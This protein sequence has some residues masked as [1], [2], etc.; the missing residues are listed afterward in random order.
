MR[1]KEIASIVMAAGRGSR[2]KGYR[3]NK[4]LLPLKPEGSI[5]EGSQPILTHILDNLPPGPKA[6]VIHHCKADVISGTSHLGVTFCHQLQLNGTGG[7][8]LAAED[9]ITAQKCDS[10]I[11]TMGDV[12]FVKPET[13]LAMVGLLR[14]HDMVV[15]GFCPQDKKQYGVLEIEDDRVVRITEWKDWKDYPPE[16]QRRL[17]ICN[18]GIYALSRQV[19]LNYLPVMAARP[20]KVYKEI[21]GR[22]EAIEEFFLT[23]LVEYMTSDDRKVGFMVVEDELETMG[24]DDREALQLAQRIYR[25]S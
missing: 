4:T 8:I 14:R 23:D 1:Q 18:S 2:M 16:R 19:L 10:I 25:Q 3:G 21:N 5:Y 11:I 24:V 7:A 9:F 13:Y 22:M 6:I 17:R 20:Q 15:L 12:P